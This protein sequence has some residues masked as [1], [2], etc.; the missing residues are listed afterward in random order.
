MSMQVDQ[1]LTGG[2]LQGAGVGRLV[3][4]YDP[5]S[6]IPAGT[7]DELLQDTGMAER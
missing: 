3:R 7:V 4:A 2:A 6:K 5:A 1:D